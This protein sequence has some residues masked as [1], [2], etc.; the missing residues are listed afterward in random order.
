MAF[1]SLT[2]ITQTRLIQLRWLSVVAMG[3]ATLLSPSLTGSSD[4]IPR[5]MAVTTVVMCI[6]AF[7]RLLAVLGSAQ[8]PIHMWFSPVLQLLFD[9]ISWGIYLYFSGGSSNPLISIFLPLVAIGAIA[10]PKIQAWSLSLAAIVIYTVLWHFHQPLHITD[11]AV[12]TRMH[13]LVMWAVFTASALVVTWFTLQMSHALRTRDA[14]LAQAREQ[15]LRDD[16]LISIGSL[17]AGAAHDLSTPLATLSLLVEDGLSHPHLPPEL[18]EDFALMQRQISVCKQALAHLTQRAG[19]P[20]EGEVPQLLVPDWL[21]TSIN[22]WQAL[23]PQ[24]SVRCS[25]LAGV[26]NCQLPQDLLLERAFASLLDNAAKAQASH[27]NIH[28]CW[29]QEQL[30]LDVQDDGQG[31]S[32]EA[33]ENFIAGAPSPSANGLGI[34]L[35]LARGTLERRGGQLQLFPLQQGCHARMCLPMPL[36]A[37]TLAGS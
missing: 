29:R 21:H 15:A 25:D 4:L 37:H 8:T 31:I 18:R 7:L 28:A 20:R 19:N 1:G 6:N 2:K 27:I 32:T 34:G 10:L 9:L 16:W 26:S 14:Y 23:H 13:L 33:L 5:L 11:L 35:L 24:V 36:K 30:Q 12:A 3:L 17:A 22:A